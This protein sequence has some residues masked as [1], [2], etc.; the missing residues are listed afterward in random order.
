MKNL[1]SLLPVLL[2]ASCNK[3]GFGG[4]LIAIPVITGLIA[5]LTWYQYFTRK[6]KTG[7]TM[8]IPLGLAVLFTIGTVVALILM[9]AEK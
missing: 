7:I 2:L 3:A 5:C 1:I 6:Q 4:G 8:L 9:F